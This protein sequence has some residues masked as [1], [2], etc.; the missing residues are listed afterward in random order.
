MLFR[1]PFT[2]TQEESMADPV[3]DVIAEL[4]LDDEDLER[5]H[6]TLICAVSTPQCRFCF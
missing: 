4:D 5:T 3:I 6:L 2:F 1:S